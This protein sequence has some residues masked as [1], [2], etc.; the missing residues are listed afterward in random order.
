MITSAQILSF[1]N[2]KEPQ[3]SSK[4]P[5]LPFK[6]LSFSS[7]LKKN[8]QAE[9]TLAFNQS[10][11]KGAQHQYVYSFSTGLLKDNRV[12]VVSAASTALAASPQTAATVAAASRRRNAAVVAWWGRRLRFAMRA[13]V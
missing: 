9:T 7:P 4:E 10:S 3:T 6:E 11:L 12:L 1:I 13:A 8:R 2:P 5:Q